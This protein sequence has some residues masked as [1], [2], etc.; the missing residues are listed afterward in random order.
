MQ[1]RLGGDVGH[2]C[3]VPGSATTARGRTGVTRTRG[4][5]CGEIVSHAPRGHPTW[6]SP[7]RHPLPPGRPT[8]RRRRHNIR[9]RS[10]R[11]RR[12][13]RLRH[14]QRSSLP[15]R[16]SH[17]PRCHRPQLPALPPAARPLKPPPSQPSITL[18]STATPSRP[19]ACTH[20]LPRCRCKN[21]HVPPRRRAQEHDRRDCYLP[22]S[23]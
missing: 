21:G 22:L 1:L 17:L 16:P 23:H 19:S 4:A 3:R 12:R 20:V 10:C 5:G 8:R 9:G 7:L 15:D 18:E 11:R 13:R 2:L 14:P 6:A